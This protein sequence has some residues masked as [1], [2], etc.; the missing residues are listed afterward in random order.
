[1]PMLLKRTK[2]QHFVPQGYLKLFSV[3]KENIWVL[4]KKIGSIRTQK[5]KKT[6]FAKNFYSFK[7]SHAPLEESATTALEGRSIT[8]IKKIADKEIITPKDLGELANFIS[9]QFLRTPSAKKRFEDVFDVFWSGMRGQYRKAHEPQKRR[10]ESIAR[11]LIRERSLSVTPSEFLSGQLPVKFSSEEF[12]PSIVGQ[13][14]KM[15]ERLSKQTWQ[16]LYSDKELPWI[17]TDDPFSVFDSKDEEKVFPTVT[18]KITKLIS[19][20]P[21]VLL[22][23]S[24]TTFKVETKIMLPWA[25]R[26]LNLGI[27]SSANRFVYSGSKN[28]LQDILKSLPRFK[29]NP[30]L[31]LSDSYV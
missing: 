21:E 12:F 17:T 9:L 1:M 22:A 15:A 4:D 30:E 7:K 18:G 24:G 16:F 19:L 28:V 26:A 31:F 27:A 2:N 25:I 23:I 11:S 14:F 13:G 8:I 5:I 10:L 29:K 6:G 20:S 3:D